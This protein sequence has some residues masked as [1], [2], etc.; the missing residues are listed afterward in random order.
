MLMVGGG[1]NAWQP[2]IPETNSVFLPA[3]AASHSPNR[4]DLLSRNLAGHATEVVV[5]CNCRACAVRRLVE[6]QCPE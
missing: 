1:E 6:Y 5:S 2:E 3:D 4:L